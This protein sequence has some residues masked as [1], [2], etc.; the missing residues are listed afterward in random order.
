M[1]T[2]YDED[3]EARTRDVLNGDR[4]IVDW[5]P[6]SSDS[7][8]DESSQ[9]RIHFCRTRRWADRTSDASN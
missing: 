2:K 5:N 3:R 4:V 6:R 9:P 8:S 1:T 7:T